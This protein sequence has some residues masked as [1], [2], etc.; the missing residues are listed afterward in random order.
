MKLRFEQFLKQAGSGAPLAQVYV[1]SGDEPLQS[2][3]ACEALRA[4]AREQGYSERKVMHV[5]RGFDWQQLAAEADA[6]SLFAE[7]RLIELRMPTGK[8]GDTGAK[9]LRAYAQRPAPDT[10]LLVICGKLESSQQKSK[11]YGALEQAGVA[12]QVWPVAAG[13]LPRWLRERMRR[14]GLNAGDA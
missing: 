8:P 12:L 10:V 9:A 13:Q 1:V 14:R 2:G 11:W 5:E 3:E 4:A 7:R 6:L